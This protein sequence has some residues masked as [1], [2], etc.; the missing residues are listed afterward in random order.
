MTGK[1]TRATAQRTPP[2]T[3][4][5]QSKVLELMWRL[6]RDDLWLS[7]SNMIE[8]V[9]HSSYGNASCTG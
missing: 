3:T 2:A 6:L 4:L 9:V 1:R 8:C 7:V 5:P